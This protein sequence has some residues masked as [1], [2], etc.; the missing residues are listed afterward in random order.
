MVYFLSVCCFWRQDIQEVFGSCHL[1]FCAVSRLSAA[2]HWPLYSKTFH[3]HLN[4]FLRGCCS[5]CY[6]V[7]KS[8]RMI[9]CDN[10]SCTMS[11]R[12]TTLA[13]LVISPAFENKRERKR[14]KLTLKSTEPGEQG[15]LVVPP[16]LWSG[17]QKWLW[18]WIRDTSQQLPIFLSPIGA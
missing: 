13:N 12:K 14:T 6:R 11:S 9:L 17:W 10:R 16:L 5:R 15:G 4:C 18:Q 3:I 7:F 1:S 2:S 8:V